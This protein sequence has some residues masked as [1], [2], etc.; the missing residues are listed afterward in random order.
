MDKEC[1][2][3]LSQEE[4][5]DSICS[6][7]SQLNKCVRKMKRKINNK[8]MKFVNKELNKDMRANFKGGVY[9]AESKEL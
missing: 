5:T 3:G 8:V 2:K 4:R 7:C 1:L 9:N 6:N